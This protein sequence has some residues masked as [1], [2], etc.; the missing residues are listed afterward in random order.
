MPVRAAGG[1]G[2]AG[3][4]LRRVERAVHRAALAGKGLRGI[5]RE[6]ALLHLVAEPEILVAHGVD[7][8]RLH[9]LVRIREVRVGLIEERRSLRTVLAPAHERGEAHVDRELLRAQRVAD[10]LRI[11]RAH[12]VGLEH[13]VRLRARGLRVV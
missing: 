6:E 1:V 12:P 3:R 2:A 13:L 10:L 4:V 5:L 7:V 9:G 8:L 11:D